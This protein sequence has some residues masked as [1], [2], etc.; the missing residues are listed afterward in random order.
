MVAANPA[1]PSQVIEVPSNPSS[2]SVAAMLRPQSPFFGCASGLSFK[3]P[4]EDLDVTP[5]VVKKVKSSA[6][7]VTLLPA[8]RTVAPDPGADVARILQQLADR[9]DVYDEECKMPA[10]PTQPLP[11][12]YTGMHEKLMAATEPE[13][14]KVYA[15]IS[16]FQDKGRIFADYHQAT[17]PCWIR[18]GVL[19]DHIS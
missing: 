2:P 6:A 12:K 16:D 7:L 4:L 11:L 13:L 9:M 1:F 15:A 10:Q 5:K 19:L 17:A 14:M 18:G 3:T 8:D